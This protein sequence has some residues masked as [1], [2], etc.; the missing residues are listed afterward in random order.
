MENDIINLV[1][2]KGQIVSGYDHKLYRKDFAGAW[3]KYTDYG[4]TDSILGWEVD[5]II[6]LARGGSDCIDNL[7]PVQW[8]NNR[9][10]GDNY[11]RYDT[12]ITSKG[13]TNVGCI[14]HW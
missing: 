7:R 1:W 10:K 14:Q 4:N 6:P 3:M 11:P 5:H 8:C 12:T 2:S 9:E 13:N